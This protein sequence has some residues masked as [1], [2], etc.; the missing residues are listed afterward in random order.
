MSK[1]GA[2]LSVFIAL[3]CMVGLGAIFVS[4]ASPY[5]TVAQ[6]KESS[7]SDLH[8]AGKIIKGT[9]VPNPLKGELRFTL[10]DDAGGELPVIYTGPPPANLATAEMVVVK[11]GMK[12]Q[13]FHARDILVKCP[14]R[15]EKKQ[16][17]TPANE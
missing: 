16:G 1:S 8:V 7:A 14:T 6:A 17:Y 13:A 4:N 2:L 9:E 12:E 10:R 5:A 3:A 11:G 15:Y